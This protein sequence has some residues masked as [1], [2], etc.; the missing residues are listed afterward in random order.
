MRAVIE[1]LDGAP[2]EDDGA[3]LDG[4]PLK[5]TSELDGRPLEDLD[6][7]PLG[8]RNEEDL[9]GMPCK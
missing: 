3:A 8:I 9:D 2:M 7:V 6:G 1:D 5:D 4:D